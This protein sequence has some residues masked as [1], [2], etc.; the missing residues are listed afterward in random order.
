[1]NPN[2]LENVSTIGGATTFTPKL[3]DLEFR[4]KFVSEITEDMT[5]KLNG[6]IDE[7]LSDLALKEEGEN[8]ISKLLKAV[9]GEKPKVTDNQT[10]WVKDNAGYLCQK[11]YD[12]RSPN[13]IA[14]N[15]SEVAA[16]LC[17]MKVIHN[18]GDPDCTLD[19]VLTKFPAE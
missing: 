13:Q 12:T 5:N 11:L 19:E 7:Y 18:C 4:K 2:K 17:S 10:Q 1:M 15:A 8:P 14:A 16:A 6:S 3:K 9:F